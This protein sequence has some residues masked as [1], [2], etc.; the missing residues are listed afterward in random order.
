MFVCLLVFFFLL[1]QLNIY[2]DRVTN[3]FKLTIY[4]QRLTLETKNRLEPRGFTS[5]LQ[6]SSGDVTRYC[7]HAIQAPFVNK[8]ATAF[9]FRKIAVLICFFSK[10]PKVWN[11]SLKVYNFQARRKLISHAINLRQVCCEVTDVL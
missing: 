2:I 3:S 8:N 7:D 10:K 4:S 9:K 1:F 6:T 5:K 11:P